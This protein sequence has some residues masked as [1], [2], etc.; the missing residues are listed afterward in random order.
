MERLNNL[1]KVKHQIVT[2]DLDLGK[3]VGW[4]SVVLSSMVAMSYRAILFKFELLKIKLNL[5][6]QILRCTGYI[7]STQQPHVAHTLSYW[8]EEV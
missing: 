3:G 8:T 4:L 6:N 2:W 5:K 7:S 1:L